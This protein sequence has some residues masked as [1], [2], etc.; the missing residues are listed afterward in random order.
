MA[1]FS[2]IS[3]ITF[4]SFGL[5]YFIG[6]QSYS[7][8]SRLENDGSQERGEHHTKKQGN[9]KDKIFDKLA[10]KSSLLDAW[11][12]IRQKG[13]A[14]GIDGISVEFYSKKF[15]TYIDELLK[16]L[17]EQ[18]YIPEPYERI[19]IQKEGKPDEQRHLSLPT[20]N[21]KIVQQA[22]RMLLE[23]VFNKI[24]TDSSYAYRPRKGPSKAIT[25]VSHIMNGTRAGWAVCADIDRFFDTMDHSFLLNEIRKTVDEPEILKLVAMWMKIGVVNRQGIYEDN[26]TGV[27]QGGII[28][29]LFS[30]IYLHP[31]DEYLAEKGHPNVRYA[32]NIILL[33]PNKAGAEVMFDDTVYF[34]ENVL[35]LKFNP[36]KT[37]FFS[38]WK[39]FSFMGIFFKGQDRFIEHS[40]TQRM[41]NRLDTLVRQLFVNNTVLFMEKLEY[42]VK[43]FNNYYARLVS[44]GTYHDRF[45]RFL[46]E[47]IVKTIVF[48]TEK[49]ER[50]FTKTDIKAMLA[51]IILFGDKDSVFKNKWIMETTNLCAESHRTKLPHAS[52]GSDADKNA[53]R[54]V[55]KQKARYKKLESVSREVVIQTMGVFVGRNKTNLVVKKKG[56]KLFDFPLE[57]LE[58]LSIISK[59]VTLSSDIILYCSQMDIPLYIGDGIDP[60]SCALHRPVEGDPTL[61]L[62]QLQLLGDCQASAAIA[63]EV[64]E[65]KIRNQINLLKYYRRSRP[66]EGPYCTAVSEEVDKM[67]SLLQE[68][69]QTELDVRKYSTL[70]NTLMGYEAQAAKRYWKL[71]KILLGNDVPEFPG[72]RRKGAKDLVNS[73]LNYGYGFLYRQVWREVVCSGLNSKISFLHSPT[74]EKPTLVFDLM[75]EFRPQAVDR[76]VFS[77]LTKK[78]QLNVNQKTGL[79]EDETRKKMIESLL[80]RQGT[81]VKYRGEKIL[82]KDIIKKQIRDFC[83]HLKGETTY[84]HFIGYY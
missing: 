1:P 72:R 35:K 54:A 15:N 2:F 17:Q 80:E 18:S 25:R 44:P 45:N 60:P 66:E 16:S 3:A 38:V 63:V 58:T 32:D 14:G 55:E 70:R 28:S 75:E 20:I 5:G 26:S 76:V 68:L 22:L 23:P 49:K 57:K 33:S 74:G 42:T 81:A 43:G 51:P 36:Q 39:G 84:R 31:L 67:K 62:L 73:L 77:M 65:G 30:N 71:V 69:D 50:R 29:P 46:Q 8:Y 9:M 40:R 56:V 47:K 64:I 82:L 37:Y 13:K 12:I 24:F 83:R 78:E 7:L 61:G 79:L 41:E 34:L 4:R 27:A 10:T 21:D 59:G 52:S 11:R 53:G 6:E 48:H 19:S